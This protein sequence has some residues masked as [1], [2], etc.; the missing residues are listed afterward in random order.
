MGPGLSLRLLSA[1]FNENGFIDEEDLQKIVLRLLR[2]DDVSEDL[3]MDV[4]HHVCI[5]RVGP[6]VPGDHTKLQDIGN[7]LGKGSRVSLERAA[8]IPHPS[9]AS[10][11]HGDGQHVVPEKWAHSRENSASEVCSSSTGLLSSSLP[12]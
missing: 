10:S 4:A 6:E 12:S 7:L 11:H 5:Q 8:H 2:S 3:L 1:D 9:P